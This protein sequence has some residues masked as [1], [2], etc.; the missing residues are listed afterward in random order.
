MKL[1]SLENNN[2]IN[3]KNTNINSYSNILNEE[4]RNILINVID[5]NYNYDLL[6]SNSSIEPYKDDVKTDISNKRENHTNKPVKESNLYISDKPIINLNNQHV[7]LNETSNRKN[8]ENNI[9]II[10]DNKHEVEDKN[11]A[12]EITNK[13]IINI[14]SHEQ[15]DYIQKENIYKF[16]NNEKFI[17]F[18]NRKFVASARFNRYTKLNGIKRIIFKCINHR[19]NEHIRIESNNKS[20]CNS[21][22]EYIYPNEKKQKEGYYLLKDH[23]EECNLLFNRNN[24]RINNILDNKKNKFFF[25]KECETIMDNSDIYDLSLF[26]DEFKKIYNKNKYNFSIDNNML[27]NIITN[28]KKNSIR[29]KKISVFYNTHD[30]NNRKILREYR[31]IVLKYKKKDKI[32]EYLIYGN[33]ENILRFI[34]SKNIFIDDTFHHPPDFK[35]LLIFMYKD[36][37]TD[38]KIPVFYILMNSKEQQLYDLVFESII[39]IINSFDITDINIETVVTNQETALINIV[40]KYFPKTQRIS[41]YFHYKSDIFKNFKKY[42]LWKK[43]Q[44]LLC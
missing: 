15:K 2:D 14:T 16:E 40:Y 28:W 34:K 6:E 24:Y 4:W 10:L 1:Y 19:K 7:L 13:N 11:T 3:K 35:Q 21:T 17:L 29:F 39:K 23:S 32:F 27:S 44:I 26:K 33:E 20:F 9:N 41:C 37:I 25:I 38:K 5:Y 18:N 8:L 12:N 36:I 22:I 42:G 30:Y 31:T 43:K